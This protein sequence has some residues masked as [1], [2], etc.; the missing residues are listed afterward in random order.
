MKNF[1]ARPR[2]MRAFLLALAVASPLAAMA[3][4]SGNGAAATTVAAA[5]APAK[6]PAAP[7]LPSAG[8]S[9]S[10]PVVARDEPAAP[11]TG[12]NSGDRVR[13]EMQSHVRPWPWSNWRS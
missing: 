13:A 12:P 8:Q 3:Q 7:A 10:Q 4:S 11:G 6:Q 9:L 2:L 1:H 5:Q